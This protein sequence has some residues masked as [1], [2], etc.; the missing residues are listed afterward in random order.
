MNMLPEA[1]KSW[2]PFCGRIIDA[3]HGI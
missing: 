2:I 3:L 1:H